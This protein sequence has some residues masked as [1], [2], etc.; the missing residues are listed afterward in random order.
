MFL[1]YICNVAIIVYS[2]RWIEYR[3]HTKRKAL[4]MGGGR[5]REREKERERKRE[6]N[7]EREREAP[8]YWSTA[9]RDYCREYLI[10][11]H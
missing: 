5:T 11:S 4:N 3:I 8:L 2:E 6:R 1:Q 10:Y 7:R 9:L